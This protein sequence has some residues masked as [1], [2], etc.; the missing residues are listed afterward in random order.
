[1]LTTDLYPFQEEAVDLVLDLGYGLIAYEMGLGKTIVGIAVVEELLSEPAVNFALIVVPSGLKYQWAESIAR[2][3][4]VTTKTKKVKRESITIPDDKYCMVV[5]GS[6]A[7]RKEQYKFIRENWPNYVIMSYEQVVNDWR[8]VRNLGAELVILDEAT[9]I[10]G[11]KAQRSKKIKALDPEFAVALTGTPMEN[12]PEETYSIMEFVCPGYLGDFE[13]F[14]IRYIERNGYGGVKRYRNLD[15]LH[16]RLS[17][18]MARKTRLDPDVAPY[19]PEVGHRVE[20]VTMSPRVKKLYNQISKEVQADLAEMQV[21]SSFDLAAYYTGTD[22]ASM[23]EMGKIAAKCMALQMLCDHPELLRIS[24]EKYEDSEGEDGSEYAFRLLKEGKLDDLGESDKMIAV[25]EDAEK[26]LDSHPDNK[27]IIFS[28]YKAMGYLLQEALTEYD[29]V[30]YN[31]DM[32][33][34]QKAEAKARFQN[35]KDCRL[36]ISSDAGAFGVDLPQA[37]YLFNYDQVESAGKMDQR[38]GRH[39]RAGSK[40]SKVFIVNYLV[41]G[42]VE[43]RI[44]D[45]LNFKRRVSRAII[46]GVEEPDRVRVGGMDIVAHTKG[47]IENT[48]NNLGAFLEAMSDEAVR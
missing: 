31:G 28:F 40:H 25:V 11:F 35:N 45:R 36:F 5:D 16:R 15:I 27:I 9:A 14:D 39:V 37:N 22:D 47:A 30:I 4:D 8:T 23:R 41:E 32:S 3:T 21:T 2:F 10:K 24:A 48:V 42:S 43:E 6:P 12:R 46:D 20:L 38:G 13:H 19:M 34:S 1:M 29:S 44:Y 26:I 7:K 17:K 18:V 33:V